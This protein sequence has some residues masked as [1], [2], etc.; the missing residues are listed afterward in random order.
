[1][2]PRRLS[3]EQVTG[4]ARCDRCRR[5]FREETEAKKRVWSVELEGRV[6]VGFRCPRC[7]TA[8]EGTGD[9]IS[10]ATVMYDRD[11]AGRTIARLR[12]SAAE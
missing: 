7:R 8:E 9:A 4:T 2:E 5:L 12:A 11:D 3:S 6:V 10:V 1:M